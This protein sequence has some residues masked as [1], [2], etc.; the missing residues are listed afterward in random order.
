MITTV[1]TTGS[2]EVTTPCAL[3][4]PIKDCPATALITFQR[5]IMSGLLDAHPSTSLRQMDFGGASDVDVRCITDDGH[6]F[7]ACL[8]PIG[9]PT[10]TA[11]LEELVAC[12]FKRFVVFG[13]CGVLVPGIPAGHIIVPTR[14]VRDEG[15]SY[16]YA[17]SSDTIDIKTAPK[18][19]AI[20]NGVGVPHVDGLVWTTDA[21]YRETR[22]LVDRR[23]SQGCIAVDME[24][25]ALAAMSQFRGVDVYHILCAADSLV[26]DWDPEPIKTMRDAQR[27]ALWK[28]ALGVAKRVDDGAR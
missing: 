9:A 25:S 6:R 1:F 12:G 16:H 28:A 10:A 17:R 26:G 24:A 5:A 20:L 11:L 13:I 18:L 19:A 3:T 7:G 15:T 2:R 4:E 8:S 27:S 22:A 23:V 21:F 14:A